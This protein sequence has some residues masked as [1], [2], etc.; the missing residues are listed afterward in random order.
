MEQFYEYVNLI[1]FCEITTKLHKQ[2]I[3][4]AKCAFLIMILTSLSKNYI[5]IALDECRRIITGIEIKKQTKKTIHTLCFIIYHLLLKHAK[6]NNQR[7]DGR[8]KALTAQIVSELSQK[9][10]KGDPYYKM[11]RN[12]VR[13][14]LT[15]K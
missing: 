7:L 13:V 6:N 9:N 10:A 2:D 11:S 12:G 5:D 4:R 1:N 3:S 8:C 15:G 14:A